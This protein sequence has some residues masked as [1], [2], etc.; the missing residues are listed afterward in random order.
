MVLGGGFNRGQ[1]G[2]VKLAYNPQK[3]TKTILYRA[4]I[5]PVVFPSWGTVLFGD[6]TL[7]KRQ[8]HLIESMYEDCLS[9]L[10]AIQL[11]FRCLNSTMSS[12]EMDSEI[13]SNL[14]CVMFKEE[15]VTD[16]LVV[17]DETNNPGS[18]VDRNEFVNFYKLGRSINFISLNFID[19]ENWCGS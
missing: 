15:G 13:K 2:V 6:K 18:V 8:V 11:Q 3:Q 10:K 5:N 9:L 12:R 4:R 14:S 16:F 1:V 19:F 7:R 17:C